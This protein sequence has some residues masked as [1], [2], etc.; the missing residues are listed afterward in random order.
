MERFRLHATQLA[1]PALQMA[2][3]LVSG[4]DGELR[5][6]GTGFMVAP[7]QTSANRRLF[8]AFTV[9]RDR[10]RVISVRDVNTTNRQYMPSTKKKLPAFKNESRE[11][12]FWA[13]ADST[14]YVD[15]QSA[16]L[17]P[18]NL[19]DPVLI[20]I[21]NSQRKKPA[22]RQYSATSEPSGL[23]TATRWPCPPRLC[24][25]ATIFPPSA[26]GCCNTPRRVPT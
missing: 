4:H 10:S 22:G 11:R 3:P 5:C 25:P 18:K 26:R 17:P 1:H 8:V 9:R 6:I 13:T 24:A 19:L 14:Q 23:K 20:K 16:K 15:W 2:Q 21:L 7:G 12:E